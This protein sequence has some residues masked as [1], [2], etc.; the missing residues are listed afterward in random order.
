MPDMKVSDLEKSRDVVGRFEPVVL[1]GTEGSVRTKAKIDPAADR[2]NIGEL[3][4]NSIGRSDYNGETDTIVGDSKENRDTYEIAVELSNVIDSR[5]LVQPNEKDR[6]NF[7]GEFLIGMDL[8]E[9]FDL[10]IDPL[11]DN[12]EGQDEISEKRK[13]LTE[14]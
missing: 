5:I 13:K 4:L 11:V 7:T 14:A 3:A 6:S 8:L 2:S 9:E 12:F 1:T 10:V